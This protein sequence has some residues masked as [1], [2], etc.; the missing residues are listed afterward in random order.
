MKTN[1]YRYF[2]PITDIAR[3]TVGKSMTICTMV[4]STIVA[5]SHFSDGGSSAGNQ[6]A[7]GLV[8]ADGTYP[9]EYL[10]STIVGNTEVGV[11][12]SF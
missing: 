12:V 10:N 3:L 8:S 1:S 9:A 11:Y 4:N 2:M 5:A 7:S 6:D